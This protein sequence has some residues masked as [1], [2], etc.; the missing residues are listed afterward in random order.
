MTW[1]GGQYHMN[2]RIKRWNFID[3]VN[4]ALLI[5][6]VLFLIDFKNNA[7]LTWV[8]I[9]V[10][11]FWLITVILRN[12]FISRIEKDPNHPMYETQVKGKKKI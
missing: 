10:F 4:L 12:I 2:K 3:T 6:V 11:I 5:V 7:A 1:I 8:L 9:A